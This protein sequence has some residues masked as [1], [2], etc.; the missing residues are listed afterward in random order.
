MVEHIFALFWHL[1]RPNWSIFGDTVSL[2]KIFENG[3]KLF[4]KENDV[5]FE[6]FRK[7]NISL[8]LKK[9]INLNAK[10]AKWSVKI[11]A[12]NFFI[13]FFK[14]ILLYTDSQNHESI[15][16]VHMYWTF[17]RIRDTVF[18]HFTKTHCA[19]KNWTIWTQKVPKETWGC[20]H[21]LL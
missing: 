7:F 19:S 1:L 5:N 8:C 9:L 14:N 13:S 17:G 12:T 4:S 21:Q 15:L 10:G 2:W 16:L 11:W 6:F 3:K 18:I 20:E